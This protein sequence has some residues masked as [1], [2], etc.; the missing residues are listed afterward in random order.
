MTQ[1]ADLLGLGL[2]DSAIEKWKEP[3]QALGLPYAADRTV[4]WVQPV[5]D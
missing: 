4:P 1:L 3:K 5:N 2:T